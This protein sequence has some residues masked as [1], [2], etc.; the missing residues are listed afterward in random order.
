MSKVFICYSHADKEYFDLINKHL[1]VNKKDI[2]IWSD[3]KIEGGDNWRN[4]IHKALNSC[5]LAVLI[6]SSNFFNSDFR[7]TCKLQ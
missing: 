5:N 6:L 7:A 2:D 3:I 4:E 1:S